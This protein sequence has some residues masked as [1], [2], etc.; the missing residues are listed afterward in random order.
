MARSALRRFLAAFAWRNATLG[1]RV[2][3]KYLRRKGAGEPFWH[4]DT[5]TGDILH[6]PLAL[7]G[8]CAVCIE[9]CPWSEPGRGPAISQAT[10]AERSRETQGASD[11]SFARGLT[12]Y[13]RADDD[14]RVRYPR[15]GP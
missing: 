6:I 13:L 8:G 10:L 9:V 14:R 7:A 15:F 4:G 11:P 2:R 5:K 3:N 12:Q 1:R